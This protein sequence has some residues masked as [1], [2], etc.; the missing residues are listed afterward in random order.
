[1]PLL[2]RCTD[3]VPSEN[4][5]E[6]VKRE[7]LEAVV[8]DAG[9]RGGLEHRVVDRLLRRLSDGLEE[10]GDLVVW[11]VLD[12]CRRAAASLCAAYRFRGREGEG[13][14]TRAV[15]HCWKRLLD[16]AR[17]HDGVEWLAG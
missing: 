14:V 12:G 15:A 3:A 2:R 1:V 4:F 10:R 16:A 5:L 8:I 11:Q 9:R 13:V 7:R 17:I 6:P